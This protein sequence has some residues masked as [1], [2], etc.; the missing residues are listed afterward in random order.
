MHG[1][2]NTRNTQESDTEFAL[3][4]SLQCYKI[5]FTMR[6]MFV[7]SNSHQHEQKQQEESY[8]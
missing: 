6:Q 5:Q 7:H 8:A 2:Q 1:N 3:P 4:T